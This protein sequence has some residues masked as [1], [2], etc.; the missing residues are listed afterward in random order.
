MVTMHPSSPAASEERLRESLAAS[1][2]PSTTVFVFIALG[3]VLFA[4]GAY[5]FVQASTFR[6]LELAMVIA[7]AGCAAVGVLLF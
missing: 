2:V 5:R 1:N 7:G 6:V 3:A 4:V